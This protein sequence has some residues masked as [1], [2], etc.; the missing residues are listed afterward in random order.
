MHLE[1]PCCNP[2]PG[3]PAPITQVR[4]PVLLVRV[5]ADGRVL[6]AGPSVKKFLFIDG[7]C[8]YAVGAKVPSAKQL[9][10]PGYLS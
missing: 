3:H 8:M 1:K 2:R 9:A 6:I 7:V 4:R 5:Q 10:E